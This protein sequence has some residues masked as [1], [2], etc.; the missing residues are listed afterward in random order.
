MQNSIINKHVKSH[1][2]GTNNIENR[3]VFVYHPI[4]Q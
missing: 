4:F 1:N 3:A 2:S